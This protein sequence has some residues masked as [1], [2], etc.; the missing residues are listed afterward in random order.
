MVAAKASACSP[1]QE[2]ALPASA[3]PHVVG[4]PVR[5][6]AADRDGPFGWGLPMTDGSIIRL[7]MSGVA[8]RLP[9]HFSSPPVDAFATGY[10]P[11]W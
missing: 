5:D 1:C 10:E 4:G 2:R 6:P 3:G 8:L 7:L 11:S 9:G